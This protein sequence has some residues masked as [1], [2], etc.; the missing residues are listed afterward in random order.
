MD[1]AFQQRGDWWVCL[2]CGLLVPRRGDKPPRATCAEK[3]RKRKVPHAQ[4]TR[5]EKILHRNAIVQEPPRAEL[6]RRLDICEACPEYEGYACITLGSACR[7]ADRWQERV[8]LGSC[9]RLRTEHGDHQPQP[10]RH[11]DHRGYYS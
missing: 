9:E 1:C 3:W 7:K 11:D 2:Q 5:R 4:P 10:C 8:L 6:E